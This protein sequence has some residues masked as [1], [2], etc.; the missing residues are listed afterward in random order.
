MG[1]FFS[2]EKWE[3]TLDETAA[4]SLRSTATYSPL[5]R[6]QQMLLDRPGRLV[7]SYPNAFQQV[8]EACD[9]S[10]LVAYDSEAG[11]VYSGLLLTAQEG[12]EH[13]YM[14][15]LQEVSIRVPSNVKYQNDSSTMSAFSVTSTSML[16][17]TSP[18]KRMTDPLSLSQFAE[19]GPP[20][21]QERC[22]TYCLLYTVKEGILVYFS[23]DLA[24]CEELVRCIAARYRDES[25][26]PGPHVSR[27]E[28][29]SSKHFP[30]IRSIHYLVG[31]TPPVVGRVLADLLPAELKRDFKTRCEVE[32]QPNCTNCIVFCMRCIKAMNLCVRGYDIQRVCSDTKTIG[33]VA[34][35]VVG[36]M[37]EQLW[38]KV[39][40]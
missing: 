4:P 22:F 19:S 33:P 26:L 21:S 37:W 28:E 16:G 29:K 32:Q 7:F 13:K 25:R 6:D 30:Q 38:R 23:H 11:R 17:S 35:Q 39:R 40:A 9:A 12:F 1:T 10:M 31:R 27:L 20:P 36:Q 3:Q 2:Q 14:R 5:V 18:K 34:G 24:S 8:S 15:T